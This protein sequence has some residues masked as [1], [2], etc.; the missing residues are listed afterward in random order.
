M[1]K[2]SAWMIKGFEFEQKTYTR[3]FHTVI[4]VI[5]SCIVTDQSYT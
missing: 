4:N 1:D 2:K 3:W 5:V